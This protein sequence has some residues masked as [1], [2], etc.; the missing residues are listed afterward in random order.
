[1][2]RCFLN[3][4][5]PNHT[6]ICLFVII[7]SSAIFFSM[8][9]NVTGQF[10]GG[11]PTSFSGGNGFYSTGLPGY[12]SYMT[13]SSLFSSLTSFSYGGQNLYGTSPYMSTSINYGSVFGGTGGFSPLTFQSSQGASFSPYYNSGFGQTISSFA[14][15]GWGFSSPGFAYQPFS[16]FGSTS[17][18]TG[19][20]QSNNSY[21]SY[22]GTQSFGA[23]GSSLFG[24]SNNWYSGS[25]M[26]PLTWAQPSALSY[27]SYP[28]SQSNGNNSELAEMPPVSQDNGDGEEYVSNQIIVKFHSDVTKEKQKMIYD[29]HGCKELYESEY[30]GFKVVEIPAGSTVEEMVNKYMQEAE[31]EYA[32]PNYIRHSHL[33]PNDRYFSYQWHHP[34]MKNT[35]A[36][37]L[38][39]GTGVTVALLDSGVAYRTSGTYVQASD[40]AGTSFRTGWDFVNSDPYPDDDNGHGTHMAGCIAQSTNNYIGVAGV[41]YGATIL[42][43]KVMDNTG[44]VSIADEVDG[45]YYAVNNGAHIINLS[46]GGEGTSESEETAINY[47][48]D[49][50]VVVICSAGNSGSS[51][52]EYPASY[53]QSISVSA[54]RYDKTLASYSNYGSA[55]DICAPGGDISVDQNFDFYGDGILQQTHDGTNLSTFY[56]Y[57]M[58]GTSPAAALVSGV[59]ALVIGKSTS[60]LSPQQ[61]K[62][63]LSSSSTDLGAV[64]WDQYYGAG[65]VNSYNALLI[66]N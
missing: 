25:I 58:E 44:S 20:I 47:A 49:N 35:S 9:R 32:E 46:L 55:I 4:H 24:G 59:A 1:M 15:S 14:P 45:I 66:T 57:F 50:G 13:G 56:Y 16:S 41:A 34:L 10:F 6:L 39:R 2:F 38:G 3:K 26:N 5:Y 31:V 40:L 54:V 12:G 52:L 51:T 11:W 19:G 17:Q 36:W 43:V 60:N 30:A 27:T 7:F 65:L 28:V 37:D 23:T 63:I 64:G 21:R 62:T 33:V 48:V 8:S 18:Y 22:S 29:K 61:V 42:P 53:S